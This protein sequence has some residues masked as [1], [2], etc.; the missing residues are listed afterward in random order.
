M[1]LNARMY[2]S[3]VVLPGTPRYWADSLFIRPDGW[4]LPEGVA[5]AGFAA[6]IERLERYDG[7]DLTAPITNGIC[8]PVTPD[9]VSRRVNE[10]L[11]KRK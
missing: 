9:E 11:T 10:Y 8:K 3:G 5:P 2:V 1:H 6:A 7:E 4:P